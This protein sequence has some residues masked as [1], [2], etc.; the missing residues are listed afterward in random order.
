MGWVYK[1]VE[2][3]KGTVV[4]FRKETDKAIEVLR[5]FGLWNA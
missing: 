5:R 1:R 2:Y 3:Q 4:K